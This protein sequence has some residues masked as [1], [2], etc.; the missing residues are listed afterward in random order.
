LRPVHDASVPTTLPTC[1]ARARL[2]AAF[3]CACS[4]VPALGDT[5]VEPTSACP[6]PERAGREQWKGQHTWQALEDAKY[7][8]EDIVV[9]VDGVFDL[10]NPQEDTWY[11]RTADALHIN[12]HP[13]VIRNE[14]LIEPGQPVDARRIY[15]SER[16]L[17]ALA[18]LRYADIVPLSCA[19]HTVV[20][21]AHVKDAWSLKFDLS[22]A[23]VGGQ[24]SLGASFED[25]DF[26]G[27]GK[28][29]A[30]GHK[31]DTQRTSNQV[32]Y[33]DPA[34]F[35]SRWTLATTYAH[36]SDGFTR[37][38]DVGQP[39]YEDQA[40]WSL[41]VHYLDQQ[42]NLNF[43]D[44]SVVGW[45]AADIT[46]KLELDWM[47]LLYWDGTSDSGMRA[48]VS[49]VSQD[50]R[51]G[52]L[53]LFPPTALVRPSLQPRRYAGPAG[54]YE[55]FQDHYGTFT[56][57]ALIGR[58]EDY[59]LGWDDK[60]QL[61]YFGTQFG[62]RVPAWFYDLSSSY[63]SELPDDSLMLATGEVRGRHQQGREQ[64]L[65]GQFAF[66]L[67][68]QSLPSQT[69]V[70]HGEIGYG[71]RSDPEDF[72]YLGGVQG[73]PGYPNYY[74]IGDRRWQAHLADRYITHQFIFNIFQVGF[75]VYGD[76]G[77]IR[78]L[79]TAGWS[80]TLI[81]AGVALRL[82]DVR[83][84]YGGVIYVTYAWPLVKLPGA[85]ERQF[86]I[87]NIIPF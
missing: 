13:Y 83:S 28:T 65:L 69:L 47:K 72:Q 52:P 82:G 70:A 81:D 74:L 84:A 55:Y 17:R 60:A 87:G 62:S 43:Y 1:R 51:Y 16:R 21:E 46:Q 53:Q 30:V 61:G 8:I 24:S 44:D 48:G 57:R 37:S 56:N 3:L 5:T 26:L 42:Q 40:P 2:A 36:L 12:T 19:D 20:V 80:R 63:G 18:Y 59:N 85:T 39:F 73:M 32:S 71:L 50:V 86:V 79:G 4:A 58:T 76:A 64:G 33:Q 29:L 78:Q 6:A 67:Y 9:V 27:T 66:T 23:H 34:L 7:T 49:Y 75:E 41:F 10:N 31:T 35:G 25:V 45:R 38:L 22:F 54:T 11:G 15:E 77:Q 68:N 14:L